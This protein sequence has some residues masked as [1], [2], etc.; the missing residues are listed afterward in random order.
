M[1]E[2]GVYMRKEVFASHSAIHYSFVRAAPCH[3]AMLGAC[4]KNRMHL[5]LNSLCPFHRIAAAA[6]VVVG[7]IVATMAPQ[8]GNNKFREF[9][10]GMRNVLGYSIVCCV[11]AYRANPMAAPHT[12]APFALIIA[13]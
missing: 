9:V 1:N 4:R 13:V 6:A 7:F 8:M 3:Q 5:S 2:I 12:R 11:R 10:S